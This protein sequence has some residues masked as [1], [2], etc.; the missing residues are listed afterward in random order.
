VFENINEIVKKFKIDC[1]NVEESIEKELILTCLNNN[2][3]YKMIDQLNLV[4]Y[5]G[6]QYNVNNLD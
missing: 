5:S 2:H 6:P 4:T 1:L 3:D